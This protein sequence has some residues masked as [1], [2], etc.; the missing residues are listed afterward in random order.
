M[1]LGFVEYQVREYL[2]GDEEEI[3][4]LLELAFNGWPHFDLDCAPLDHWKWKY[5]DN[6]LKLNA[7][8][9]AVIQNKIVGCNHG[10]YVKIKIG[11]KSLLCQQGG[12]LAVHPKY[13]RMGI[14]NKMRKPKSNLHKSQKCDMT[15]SVTG[16]PI[17]IK[18]SIKGGRSRFPHP[19]LSMSRIT[20]ID[21]HLKNGAFERKW[22]K[23]LGFIYFKELNRVKNVNISSRPRH[24]FNVNKVELYDSRIDK[25]W[26]AIRD[27]YKFIV[28]RNREYLNWR[29]CDSRGGNYIIRSIE[30]SGNIIGYSV[31]RVNRYDEEY[32]RGHIV[33]LLTL[34]YRL[35][36]VDALVDD[37]ISYFNKHS[38]NVIYYWIP[39]NHPFEKV[40]RRYGF[41]DFRENVFF[42]FRP[43]R[44]GNEFVE[45]RN[46]PVDQVYIQKGDVDGI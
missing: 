45:F 32:P 7:I 23:K 14:Y 10:Y 6:P 35:D 28:E 3:V 22:M 2:P 46:A 18:S 13:R 40:F 42:G 5:L 34:P 15:F 38:V 30:E 29:Y 16:N 33:E 9:V 27:H 43:K 36:V 31:L 20:D 25:F 12:D 11:N 1:I 8:A 4:N 21:I 41:L 26:K 17:V 44:E 24:K 37:A 39:K 19:I